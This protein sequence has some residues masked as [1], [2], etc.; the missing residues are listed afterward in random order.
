MNIFDYCEND[1]EGLLECINGGADVHARNDHGDTPLKLAIMKDAKDCVVI[2]IKH[3]AIIMDSQFFHNILLIAIMNNSHNCLLFLLEYDVNGIAFNFDDYELYIAIASNYGS[4][5]SLQILMQYDVIKN[6][7]NKKDDHGNTPLH[8]AA[9]RF[10][11]RCLEILIQNG[12]DIHIHNSFGCT[13]LWFAIRYG[14]YKCTKLLLQRGADVNARN[15]D[16]HTPL[17]SA[18]L[19][20]GIQIRRK[21]LKIMKILIEYGADTNALNDTGFTF[22]DYLSGDHKEKIEK[23]IKEM[24]E[25]NIKEPCV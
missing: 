7:V 24:Q 11:N 19:A 20:F 23:I 12:G 17:H 4:I 9:A 16:G 25:Y 21:S 8:T 1:P 3:G 10:N 14:S 18:A 2:L 22:L 6:C 15:R 13:P 5:E